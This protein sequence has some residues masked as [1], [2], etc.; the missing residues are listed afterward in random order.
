MIAKIKAWFI[1]LWKDI[2]EPPPPP[3]PPDIP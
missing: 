2:F 3:P 1:A